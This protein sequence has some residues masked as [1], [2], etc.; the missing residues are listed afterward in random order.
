MK[1]ARLGLLEDNVGFVFGGEDRIE[2][3]PEIHL[4]G[5]AA[6]CT[7]LPAGVTGV[8]GATELSRQGH[9][10]WACRC[11]RGRLLPLC[12]FLHFMC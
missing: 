11:H 9:A 6:S 10:D 5:P 8:T 7:R 1:D 12:V 2:N 4:P 3:V